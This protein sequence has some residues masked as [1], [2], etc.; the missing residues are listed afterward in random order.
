MIGILLILALKDRI[1]IQSISTLNGNLALR[2][3]SSIFRTGLELDTDPNPVRNITDSQRCA[4]CMK[5]FM[6]KLLLMSF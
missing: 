1:R 6:V 4:A 2:I 3:K 5:Y